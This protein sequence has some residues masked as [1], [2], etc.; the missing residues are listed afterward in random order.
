MP[1]EEFKK[2]DIVAY[3]MPGYADIYLGEV[4]EV[5]KSGVP[6]IRPWVSHKVHSYNAGVG[7]DDRGYITVKSTVINVSERIMRNGY[8]IVQWIQL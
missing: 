7:Q 8:D 2:G 1:K 4:M 3:K 5:K 6:W